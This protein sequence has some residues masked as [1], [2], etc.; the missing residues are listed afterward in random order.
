M[1]NSE[2]RR[3]KKVLTQL[4]KQLRKNY[5]ERDILLTATFSKEGLHNFVI[6]V[7]IAK[8]ECPS[9][10]HGCKVIDSKVKY[11]FDG[12]TGRLIKSEKKE[13]ELPPSSVPEPTSGE[14]TA[15]FKQLSNTYFMKNLQ[16][17][18]KEQVF[19]R[20]QLELH[21]YFENNTYPSNTNYRANLKNA[22][23]YNSKVKTERRTRRFRKQRKSTRRNARHRV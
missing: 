9:Y 18:Q 21:K 4:E 17:K 3:T 2:F 19:N 23:T 15:L 11:I 14:I 10:L 5:P 12:T 13:G 1:N 7:N 22:I 16:A 8:D 20:Q 6:H